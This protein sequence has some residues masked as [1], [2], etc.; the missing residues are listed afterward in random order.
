MIRWC[1]NC[2]YPT[3]NM[4]CKLCGSK[5]IQ[6]SD[7]VVPVFAPEKLVISYIIGKDVTTSQVWNLGKNNYL[8]DGEKITLE[9]YK[10]MNNKR[11]LNEIRN[12][13]SDTIFPKNNLDEL[14]NFINGN[15]D[16]LNNLIV[17]VHGYINDVVKKYPNHQ[18]II[19]WSGGKDSTV[20]SDLVRNA[21][22]DQKILHIF[23]DTKMEFPTTY[24]YFDKFKENNVFTPFI[25]AK[26]E[27]SFLKLC[28]V[29]GPPSRIMRWCCS[30]FKTGPI[31][32]NF[33]ELISENILTF[34]GIRRAESVLRSHYSR[35]E[36]SPKILRQTVSAPIIDWEYFDVWLYII[37]RN[38]EFNKAY[39][40]GFRRVGCLYCP[41][42]SRWSEFLSAIFFKEQYEMWKEYLYNFAQKIGKKDY[43]E[44]IDNGNWKARQGGYGINSF[45]TK[46]ESTEC[47]LHENAQNY[48][49]D[50]PI[51]ERLI[52]YLKP[53]GA[54]KIMKENDEYKIV[55]NHINHEDLIIY[56]NRNSVIIKAIINSGKNVSI[57]KQRLE[58]QLRKYNICIQCSACDS[59]CPVGAISTEGGYQVSEKCN[60]CGK[61]IAYFTGGCLINKT[62]YK[63]N[64]SIT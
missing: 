29:F 27:K 60:H 53:L 6:L 17:E 23:G 50:K 59:V 48:I 20:V 7:I 3:K 25:V 13:V 64:K 30:I 56:F 41:N 47:N 46:L 38:I 24:E 19:S 57:I 32:I 8:I 18:L 2:K 62:L 51:T 39:R 31:S 63:S 12:K 16:Y 26:S 14:E 35:T 49:F 52:Q 4:T 22:G 45:N 11:L 43:L 15:R 58:C 10:N 37:S 55:I 5:T 34:Y 21:I 61:C 44:Y 28:D 9:Y 1:E 54:M 40:Y 33:N 36:R 42:N